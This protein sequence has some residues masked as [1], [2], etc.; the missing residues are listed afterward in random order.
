MPT[1][2][3]QYSMC[4]VVILISQ[5]NKYL[6]ELSVLIISLIAI[7]II[8]GIWMVLEKADRPGIL[9]IV[10]L[11]NFYQ[12]FQLTGRPG[13]LVIFIIL[14]PLAPAVLFVL[15]LDLARVFGKSTNF[16][17]GIFFFPFIFL[18]LL[19]FDKSVYIGPNA[20]DAATDEVAEIGKDLR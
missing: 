15:S 4:K 13:W 14:F 20:G 8:V 7:G 18:P 17:F 1:E 6:M 16:A 3:V 19:G 5:Q 12:L 11:V 10:P 9:S 2:L